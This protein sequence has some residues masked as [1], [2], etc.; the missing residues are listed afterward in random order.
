MGNE[1][2]EGYQTNKQTK[3]TNIPNGLYEI[4]HPQPRGLERPAATDD[5]PFYSKPPPDPKPTLAA[6]PLELR[7]APSRF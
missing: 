3:Q 6:R 1:T 5:V 2:L 7:T 4:L